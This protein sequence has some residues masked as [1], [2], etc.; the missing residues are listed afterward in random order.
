MRKCPLRNADELVYGQMLKQLSI[1]SK[2][3]VKLQT[4][5]PTAPLLSSHA[6]SLQT[7]LVMVSKPAT[8]QPPYRP[9][10]TPASQ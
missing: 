6:T 1:A 4:T 8:Q 10:T 9:Q 2:L 3:D 5:H 7:T